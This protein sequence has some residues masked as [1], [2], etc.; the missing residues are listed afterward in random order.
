MGAITGLHFLVKVFRLS[1]S[2]NQIDRCQSSYINLCWLYPYICF[3]TFFA[4][5][6]FVLEP[7]SGSGTPIYS[8]ARAI[9]GLKQSFDRKQHLNSHLQ[10]D[11][12][13]FRLNV[14]TI[15][16]FR[17]TQSIV[18]KYVFGHDNSAKIGQNEIHTKSYSSFYWNIDLILHTKYQKLQ[19]LV[20]RKK[21]KKNTVE[22]VLNP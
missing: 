7:T 8:G 15:R 11:W 10:V 1:G 5:F 20:F 2:Q 18:N 9:F 14:S 17:H 22:F 4:S 12:V 13:H 19:F 3:Q 16:H 21:N 6:L